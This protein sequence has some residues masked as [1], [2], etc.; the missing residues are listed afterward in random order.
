R[1]SSDL[2][3]QPQR[4]ARHGGRRRARRGADQGPQRPRGNLKGP[5]GTGR[6]ARRRRVRAPPPARTG[7]QRDQ[8]PVRRDRERATGDRLKSRDR[9][10]EET[11][12]TLEWIGD[13]VLLVVLVPVVVYLLRGV[14]NAARSIVPSVE[15]IAAT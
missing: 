11:A 5:R 3:D 14:L 13:A 4:R 10:R 2:T 1:R 8:R 12:M 9:C 6:R 15:Q 7:G